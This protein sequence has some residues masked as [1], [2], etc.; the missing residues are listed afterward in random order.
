[1]HDA[2]EAFLGDITR[3]LNQMLP[4]YKR[5]ESETERAIFSRFGITKSCDVCGI[6]TEIKAH[7]QQHIAIEQI[8]RYGRFIRQ[9]P[10]PAAIRCC[11]AS[12]SSSFARRRGSA[13]AT[14][15]PSRG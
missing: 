4:D 1:M 7:Q 12:I 8:N 2:A 15:M 10:P 5:I 9:S 11:N 13:G 3:P 14:A 6:A